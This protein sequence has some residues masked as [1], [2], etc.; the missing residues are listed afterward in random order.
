MVFFIDAFSIFDP[1]YSIGVT[2][3][4][5]AAVGLALVLAARGVR[6]HW[7]AGLVFT[8][9]MI[10]DAVLMMGMIAAASASV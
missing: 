3:T 1:W 6:F 4:P 10:A 2:M 9:L 8:I 7:W 5:M